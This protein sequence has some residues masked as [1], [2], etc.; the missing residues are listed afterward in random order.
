MGQSE[1]WQRL[2]SSADEVRGIARILPG[3]AELHLGADARKSY[4]AGSRL[5]S[6][7]LL[8]FSTHGVVDLEELEL[9]QEHLD[10]LCECQGLRELSVTEGLFAAL[11][12][13]RIRRALPQ[14]RVKLG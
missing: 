3:R 6:V 11:D 2:T 5:K 14:L 1:R 4:L 10:T 8:H 9:T 13:T 12:T 7:P